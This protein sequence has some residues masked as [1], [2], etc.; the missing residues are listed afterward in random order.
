MLHRMMVSVYLLPC[1]RR[2]V[3]A[4]VNDCPSTYNVTPPVRCVLTVFPARIVVSLEKKK[5]IRKLDRPYKERFM[6]K[7]ATMPKL[8]RFR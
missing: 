8:R 6:S 2:N 5:G 1:G 3:A 7:V 4:L